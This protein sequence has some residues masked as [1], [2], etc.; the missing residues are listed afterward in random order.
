M[1]INL[2]VI[3]GVMIPFI[4][5]SLGAFC[6][7]FMKKDL[8]LNEEEIN[9]LAYFVMERPDFHDLVRKKDNKPMEFLLIEA[10]SEYKKLADT[11]I[12]ELE[13]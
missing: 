3:Y 13:N 9:V 11:S 10:W 8:K 6:V 7:Y 2:N 12:N 5:T 1:G 4:G